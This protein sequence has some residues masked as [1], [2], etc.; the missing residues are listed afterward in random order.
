MTAVCCDFISQESIS[1]GFPLKESLKINS[2]AY[3]N[4]GYGVFCKKNVYFF[5]RFSLENVPA[6][7]RWQATFGKPHRELE[8]LYSSIINHFPIISRP[9]IA[10][11]LLS[12]KLEST[13]QS[14][15]QLGDVLM[16]SITKVYVTKVTQLF[17]EVQRHEKVNAYVVEFISLKYNLMLLG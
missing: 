8:N 11:T 5:G 15:L 2:W 9:M 7:K 14:Y 17:H 10:K 6:Q 12:Q 4:Y 16:N 3:R 1:K 13:R